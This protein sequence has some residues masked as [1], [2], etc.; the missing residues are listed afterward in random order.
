[1]CA[2]FQPHGTATPGPPPA[3]AHTRRWRAPAVVPPRRGQPGKGPPLSAPRNAVGIRSV[4]PRRELQTVLG[5]RSAP[6]TQQWRGRWG[7]LMTAQEP[8]P[9]QRSPPARGQ[10][11]RQSQRQASARS[12]PILASVGP[13]QN[14]LFNSF[15]ARR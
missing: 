8:G 9:A 14:Q 10:Q 5:A 3:A 13:K 11:T 12:S 4:N 6:D 1:M 2:R 7:M 15:A